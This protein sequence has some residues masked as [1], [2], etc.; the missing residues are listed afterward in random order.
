MTSF[1]KTN[2]KIGHNGGEPGLQV[3]PICEPSWQLN[4]QHLLNPVTNRWE[5]SP[6]PSQASAIAIDLFPTRPAHS[7][8]SFAVLLLALNHCAI[9][10]DPEHLRVVT[11]AKLRSNHR[12]NSPRM[13]LYLFSVFPGICCGTTLTFLFF[14][15]TDVG[16]CC[17]C[18]FFALPEKLLPSRGWRAWNLDDLGSFCDHAND[19]D[20]FNWLDDKIYPGKCLF[21]CF[22]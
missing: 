12:I 6:F 11:F 4:A 7:F 9:H 21:F 3:R 5:A 1:I 18:L 22:V 15:A 17:L 19:N 8:V 16:S 20:F 14:L 10:S 2:K 13:L